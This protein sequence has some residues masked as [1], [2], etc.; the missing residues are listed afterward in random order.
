MK[1]NA[2]AINKCSG[3]S[4]TTRKKKKMKTKKKKK[5]SFGGK[6]CGV[7][8]TQSEIEVVSTISGDERASFYSMSNGILPAL[9]AESTR[10][11]K[12][13]HLII[14]PFNPVYRSLFSSLLFLPTF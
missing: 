8:E 11:V 1:R 10:K 5:V 13:N 14:S 2:I 3:S 7:N 9:G 12:L 6:I 4:N